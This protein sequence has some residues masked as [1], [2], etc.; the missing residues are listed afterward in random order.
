[1]GRGLSPAFAPDESRLMID[2]PVL[3]GTIGFDEHSIRELSAGEVPIGSI[4]FDGPEAYQVAAVQT[5]ATKAVT[6]HWTSYQ[7]PAGDDGTRAVSRCR[8]GAERNRGGE[9]WTLLIPEE[10]EFAIPP[11]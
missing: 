2:S 8:R 6:G 10:R 4:P 5:E 3:S 1:M 9:A 7:G 11:L